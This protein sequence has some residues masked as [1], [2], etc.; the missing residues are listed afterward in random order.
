VPTSDPVGDPV[1]R[2][3]RGRHQRGERGEGDRRT[4]VHGV[5]QQAETVLAAL[6][7]RL[8]LRD[9]GQDRVAQQGVLVLAVER[10]EDRAHRLAAD[11]EP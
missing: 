5:A 4:V 10:G 1:A 9:R 11:P 2:L 8:A 7:H 3:R 6:R